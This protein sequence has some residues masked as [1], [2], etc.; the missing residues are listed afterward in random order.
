MQSAEVF[1]KRHR[2]DPRRGEKR[3]RG[4]WIEMEQ[5]ADREAA[6]PL[7]GHQRQGGDEQG[8]KALGSL[9]SEFESG[10]YDLLMVLNSR[11][12]QTSSL[13]GC[14]SHQRLQKNRQQE[15]ATKQ[16]DCAENRQ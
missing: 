13:D 10:N 12:P 9:S 3:E 14:I 16:A 4:E 6:D 2:Q 5:P 15:H 1:E 8:T 11:R 7:V